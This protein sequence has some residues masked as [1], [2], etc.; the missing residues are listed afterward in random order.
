MID[1]QGW[2]YWQASDRISILGKPVWKRRWVVLT[3]D[4]LFI[5]KSDKVRYPAVKL[6]ANISLGR[7]RLTLCII[8][9]SKFP[10]LYYTRTYKE[11]TFCPFSHTRSKSGIE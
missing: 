9:F 3:P 6:F 7:N 4:S 11:I 10:N 8:F 2:M 1:L 5:H